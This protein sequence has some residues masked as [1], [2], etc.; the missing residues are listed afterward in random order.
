M[1]FTQKTWATGSVERADADRWEQA[2]TDTHSGVVYLDE[3]TGTDDTR[4]TA[5]L[6]HAAAQTRIPWIEFP[7]RTTTFNEGGR[8]PFS[9]MKLRAPGGGETTAK[10]YEVGTGANVN[11]RVKLDS[12]IT[13]GTNA[14][15]NGSGP[16]NAITVAGLQF[17][18]NNSGQF[19]HQPTGT[20]YGC[21]FHSLAAYGL[22]HFF[23]SAASKCLMTQVT[24]SGQ[25]NVIAFNGSGKPQFHAG[26]SD[27]SLWMGGYVNIGSSNPGDPMIR[28]SSM[29]KTNVGYVYST[30]QNGE[31][32]LLIEGSSE[33]LCF[34]G[35]SYEGESET[36]PNYGSQVRIGGGT[37]SMR[38]PWIA[39][40]MSDPA[41]AGDGSEGVVH[42]T[43]GQVLIDGAR[44][45]RANS[46]AESV[47]LFYASGG[48][49][50]LRNIMPVGAWTGKPI[51]RQTVAGLIDADDTVTVV[52]D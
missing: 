34:Y 16:L 18:G 3:F 38:D 51:A 44:Y 21:V 24:F 30:A 26:G 39:Y 48:K 52:T 5:A 46:V 20:L 23:G 40:G 19:W 22:Q 36:E 49:T 43:G 28:L 47:P 41:L 6:T 33:G 10:H 42:I 7:A 31:R 1:P 37:V 29:S 12:G 15:F 45:K 25:W 8:S 35:G 17:T 32:G 50:R 2:H 14:L 27:N 9:G 4:L 13:T 11:H